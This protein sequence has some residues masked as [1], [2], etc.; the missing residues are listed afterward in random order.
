MNSSCTP[1][2]R[3]A[4]ETYTVQACAYYVNMLSLEVSLTFG[5]LTTIVT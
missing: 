2:E 5:L 1:S 3:I 4:G